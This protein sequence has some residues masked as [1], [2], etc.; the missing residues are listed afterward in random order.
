MFSLEWTKGQTDEQ[1]KGQGQVEILNMNIIEENQPRTHHKRDNDNEQGHDK[2]TE[3]TKSLGNFQTSII[4]RKFH[5]WSYN[6]I[7]LHNKY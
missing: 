1:T 7:E 4:A 5:V 3:D 6:L 2:S